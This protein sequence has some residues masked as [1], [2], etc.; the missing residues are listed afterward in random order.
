MSGITAIKS[1][2]KKLPGF[3]EIVSERDMLHSELVALK[4]N[5]RFV[6]PGHFYSPIPSIEDIL[7]D[8]SKIFRPFPHDIPDV[9]DLRESDQLRL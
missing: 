1:A 9:V 8:E 7:K 2:V 4:R 3:R 6:P 5:L